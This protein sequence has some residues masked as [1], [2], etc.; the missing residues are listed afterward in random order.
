MAS[1]NDFRKENGGLKD[2]YELLS[3]DLGLQEPLGPLSTTEQ[4]YHAYLQQVSRWHPDKHM[5]ESAQQRMEAEQ[6]MKAVNAAYEVLKNPD[7]KTLY[8]R[9]CEVE[10]AKK[11]GGAPNWQQPSGNR[12]A[13]NTHS[14]PPPSSQQPRQEAHSREPEDI[15]SRVYAN[16]V[17]LPKEFGRRRTIINIED[18]LVVILSDGGSKYA[19]VNGGVHV[20]DTPGNGGMSVSGVDIH[21]ISGKNPR[22]Q[23]SRETITGQSGNA[24]RRTTVTTITSAG[25]TINIGEGYS[26]SIGEGGGRMNLKDFLKETGDDDDPQNPLSDPDLRE[27]LNIHAAWKRA[28][29][30]GGRK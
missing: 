20:Y 5:G 2:Y 8:D 15:G 18:R 30:Q 6:R 22:V 19:T 14:Y 11:S 3:R 29:S 12:Q 9:I 17:E 28:K 13:P 10:K 24:Y 7:E 21:Y 23:V 1:E 16:G 25:G 27:A 26:V 4:V